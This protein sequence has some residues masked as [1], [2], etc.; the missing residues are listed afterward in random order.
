MGTGSERGDLSAWSARW[1]GAA[2]PAG[3]FRPELLG[4]PNV[5]VLASRVAGTIRAGAVLNCESLVVGLSN[6]FTDDG[7]RE[8]VWAGAIAASA[9]ALP[10]RVDRRLRI[11]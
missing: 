2:E 11:R 6:V 9:C 8:A 10:E 1:S 3:L 5:V 7:D 4:N